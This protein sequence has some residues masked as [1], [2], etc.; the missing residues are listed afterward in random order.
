[1]GIEKKLKKDVAKFFFNILNDIWIR[2]IFYLFIY[3]FFFLIFLIK[4]INLR[5]IKY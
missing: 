3:L 5:I 1:M 4:I 2:F